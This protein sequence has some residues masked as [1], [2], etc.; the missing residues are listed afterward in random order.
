MDELPVCTILVGSLRAASLNRIAA[1]SASEYL[2]YM[3]AVRSPDLGNLPLFNEDLEDAEPPEVTALK[4]DVGDSNLIIIFTPEYNYGI[5]GG[6]KN[7]IDW[8]SRPVR[9]GCLIGRYV[10]IASVGPPSLTGENVRENLTRTCNALTDYL[11][12]TTLRL[13][14]ARDAALDDLGDEAT[15]ALYDWLDGLLEFTRRS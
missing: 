10:A 3:C 14:V 6:L 1:R 11:Y 12:P 7:A 2:A 8:L 4:D 9:N 15:V 5:P 13:P